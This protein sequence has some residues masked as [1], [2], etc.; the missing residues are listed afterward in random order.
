LKEQDELDKAV[1]ISRFGFV[2]ALL[3]RFCEE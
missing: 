2:N 3:R 1:S